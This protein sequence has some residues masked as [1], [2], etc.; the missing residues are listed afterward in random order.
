MRWQLSIILII[1]TCS[2]L[3]LAAHTP[4]VLLYTDVRSGPTIGG[5]N[6]HGIYLSLFGKNFGESLNN[7]TVRIGGI[8]VSE[9]KYLGPSL[10]RSDVQQLVIQPGKEIT[11]GPIEISVNKQTVISRQLFNVQP[12][13]IFFVALNGSD[14]RG[15][16]NDIHN[17]FR[18]VQ[19]VFDRPDFE[20]GDTIIIR[21]GKWSDVGSYKAFLTISKK[22][23]SQLRP[24]RI[25]SYPGENVLIDTQKKRGAI[26]FYKTN[27]GMTI[28]GLHINGNKYDLIQMQSQTDNMRIVNNE[29]YGLWKKK[30]GSAAVT[31]NGKHWKIFGNHIHDNG[32][33]KK[34][35]GIYIDNDNGT[36]SDDIE[37]AYNHI[38]DQT[39]G[40]GVQ[41]YWKR[42]GITNIHIHDNLIHDI[43]RDAIVISDNV[44]KGIKIFNNI[45]YNS[46]RLHGSGIR[47]NSRLADVNIYNNTLFNSDVA[48][49]QGAI[50]LENTLAASI[51]NNIISAPNGEEFLNNEVAIK[52]LSISN[53]L[54]FGIRFFNTR[55]P[56]SLDRNP[57]AGDPLF[58]N[59]K[60]FNFHLQPSSPAINAGIIQD[61][62]RFDYDGSA[63]PGAPVKSSDDTQYDIGAYEYFKFPIH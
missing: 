51:H 9:Y 16:I 20:P 30:G 23:G 8:E 57:V 50:Y 31:G 3:A 17:P 37:I 2:R 11:S 33:S 19:Y 54:W 55:R 45:I 44:G 46:G 35:H 47:I 40:R 53:N 5:E 39:G 59:T 12:G 13:D 36:G 24:M 32:Y 15:K 43:D 60:I 42:P 56:P 25:L 49:N 63:R 29:L 26:S 52:N 27:G 41:I 10:G 14:Q 4:P 1:Y 6:N 18:H 22:S 7:I 48:K 28:S 58:V 61:G 62:L 34:F 21:G 38:H